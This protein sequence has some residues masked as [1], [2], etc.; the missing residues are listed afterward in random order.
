MEKSVVVELKHIQKRFGPVKANDN[1]D[2]TIRAGEIHAILGENGSGKSTLMNILSGLYAP[3]GGQIIMHGQPINIRSPKDAMDKGIGMI[4]QHFKLVDP[5]PAWENIIG[6]IQGSMLLRKKTVIAKIKALCEK[7][8]LQL[9]PEK[10]IYQ[11]TIGEKQTVEIVKA[12]YREAEVMI[13]DEPTAVLTTQETE[14][15]FKILREMRANGC[16]VIIITHKLQEVMDISDRVTTLR[17]GVSVD[18]RLTKDC[19]PEL[20]AELMVGHAIDITVPYTAVSRMGEEPILSIRDLKV[21]SRSKGERLNV[22]ELDV[23]GGEIMGVAGVAD[24]GQKELCEAITGLQ[25]ATGSVK[26]KGTELLGMNPRSM[27]KKDIQIGFVPED[28]LG[29]GLANGMDISDNVALRTYRDEKGILLNKKEEAKQAQELMEAYSV[30]AAGVHQPIQ[31]LS[32]GNIQKVLLGREIG[33]GAEFFIAAYPVRGLDIGAS[34]FIY[35][36]LNEEKKKGVGILFVGEDLDV[37][38]G[39]C[40]RIAVLYDGKLMG[41]VDAKSVT[42]EQLG[43]LMMGETPEEV[44]YAAH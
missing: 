44:L 37:M 29:M 6:G 36:K 30:S 1:V 8:K 12:L 42:K 28:R 3:D 38:L 5:L 32:G 31:M 26:L 16:A 22:A 14:R 19:T 20:L 33:R 35:E 39:I 21:T 25:K 27:L 34:D 41:V 13:L 17:K 15:L 18:S 10:C 9:D 23:W 7:Y 43:L 4:H 40:D 2:L 24:S 11:M